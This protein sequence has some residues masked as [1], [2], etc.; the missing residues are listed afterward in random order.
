MPR[1]LMFDFDGVIA[2]SLEQFERA[3]NAACAATGL[4]PVGD[5][6]AVLSLFDENMLDALKARGLDERARPAFLGALRNALARECGS[7]A[8]FPGMAGVLNELA[9]A[10]HVCIITSNISDV[11]RDVLRANGVRGIRAI[12]GSEKDAS[13]TR[14]ISRAIAACPGC[15]AFYFGDT[16]G[17]MREAREAGV[18]PVAVAWG[19]HG[20]QRLMSAQPAHSVHS[21]RDLLARYL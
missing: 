15:E 21:P 3:L 19:W 9:L 13:K 20:G 8:L 11:V 17:D 1:L 7:I 18:A 2:D 5:R 4:A 16:V 10:H 14:K 12:L 6:D